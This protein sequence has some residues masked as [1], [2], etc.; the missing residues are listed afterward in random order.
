MTDTKS[1]LK[2]PKVKKEKE[3]KVSKTGRKVRTVKK[4]FVNAKGYR[5]MLHLSA[6]RL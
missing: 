5:G 6:A 1:D 2:P 3:K 4:S